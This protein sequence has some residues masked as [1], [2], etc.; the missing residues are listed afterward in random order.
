MTHPNPHHTNSHPSS[1]GVVAADSASDASSLRHPHNQPCASVFRD[2]LRDLVNH[3][4]TSSINPTNQKCP[5]GIALARNGY[6]AWA[7]AVPPALGKWT[8]T[9]AGWAFLETRTTTPEETR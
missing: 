3:D 5:Y 8:I 7:N 1:A 6:A 2:A 9:P 4:G